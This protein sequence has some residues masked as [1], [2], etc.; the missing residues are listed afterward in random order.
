MS[1]L[2]SKIL[3]TLGNFGA[4]RRP[5]F[6]F[7]APRP[8]SSHAA[9]HPL[10]LNIASSRVSDLSSSLCRCHHSRSLL[11]A[12]RPWRPHLIVASSCPASPRAPR[13]TTLSPLTAARSRQYV[14]YSPSFFTSSFTFVLVAIQCWI[15]ELVLVAT[16]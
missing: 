9:G 8:N 3:P 5:K 15:L 11:V 10:A 6:H 7:R 13:L 12:S 2:P 1:S 14:S 4:K 16:L